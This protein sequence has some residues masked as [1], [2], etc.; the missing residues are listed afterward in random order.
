M[1]LKGILEHFVSMIKACIQNS[2]CKVSFGGPYSNEFSVSTGLIQGD[3]L[4]L[5]LFNIALDS[6]AGKVLSNSEGRKIRNN[7][8]LAVIAY[9][10]G[11]VIN[12]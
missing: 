7:Q 3:V 10:N 8:Q 1:T 2:I 12:V 9:A 5:V 4:S 11:V 6:V